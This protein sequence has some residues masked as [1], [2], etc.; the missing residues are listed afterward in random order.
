MSNIEADQLR[1]A[2]STER[3]FWT[4]READLRNTIADL[5]DLLLDCQAVL[6]NYTDVV[7][8]CDGTPR[9][10]AAMSLMQRIEE[11]L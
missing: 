2:F 1:I 7:D 8:A 10:N 9:P 6:D 5:R 3:R 11:V 4:A